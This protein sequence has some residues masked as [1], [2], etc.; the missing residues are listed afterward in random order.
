M[1]RPKLIPDTEVFSAILQLLT[2]EGD[3]AVSFSRVARITGLAPAT[4][5][6]RFGSLE[7]MMTAAL[8]AGW[9]RAE[10]DLAEAAKA[11]NDGKG[12]IQILKSLPPNTELLV[13]SARNEALR[14]RATNWR[15]AVEAALA[16]RLEGKGK[17]AQAAALLFAVWQG[18]SAWKNIGG[19]GLKLKDVFKKFL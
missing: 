6:Q 9:D 8:A 19:K 11:G 1:A 17:A 13:A 16:M 10:A 12:A 7:G 5:V 15:V 2:A 3:K 14:E 18:Q 4:L